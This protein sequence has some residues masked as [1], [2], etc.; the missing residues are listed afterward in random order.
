MSLAPDG[1]GKGCLKGADSPKENTT[2]AFDYA[3]DSEFNSA[4]STK[5]A[6]S[7]LVGRRYL[8]SIFHCSAR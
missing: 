5:N 4:C 8:C 6:S 2:A 3:K 7:L 1:D